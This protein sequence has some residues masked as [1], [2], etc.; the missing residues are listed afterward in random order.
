MK[1]S[2]IGCGRVGTTTAYAMM[3]KGLAREI[4]LVDVNTDRS[5]GEQLDLLHGTAELAN[6]DVIWGDYSRISGSDIVVITAGIP[7]K[8]GESR[9]DLAAKNINVI[10]DIGE[11][12]LANAPDALVLMVSNP[13]DVM[14][15]LVQKV[16]GERKNQVFGLGNVLDLLRF[17]SL[18]GK[19]LGVHP[20]KVNA[21]V[22]GEHGDSMVVLE[23]DI[24][25]SG[26]P[27]RHYG[28]ITEDR[29]KDIIHDTKYGGAKVI[30]LKGGTYYSVG[31]AICQV[32]EAIVYDTKE[33]L[34]V[35]YMQKYN[36]RDI[37]YSYPAI[38]GK[39]GIM[40]TLDIK[41]SNDKASLFEDSV[42]VIAGMI[43]QLG[44]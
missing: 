22:I 17:R 23:D 12:V 2:I 11:R 36:G 7:R 28:A 31:I 35:C 37:T 43:E 42:N 3:L 20:Q 1:I 10:R 9:L 15:H 19:E 6:V 4:V 18:V 5:K 27:L 34:P 30:A 13:V 24:T 40:G 26:L 39:K 44:I 32:I 41:L 33:V 21:M 25:V 14:T 8:P 38:I 29:M 16:F